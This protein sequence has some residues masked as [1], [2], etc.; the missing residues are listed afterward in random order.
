MGAQVPTGEGQTP[1]SR[2]MQWRSLHQERPWQDAG[3]LGLPGLVSGA[4]AVFPSCMARALHV[5]CF[6]SLAHSSQ[7]FGQWQLWKFT[8]LVCWRLSMGQMF[9]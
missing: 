8:L 4:R 3:G 6:F 5:L 7:L 9:D 2:K 1:F